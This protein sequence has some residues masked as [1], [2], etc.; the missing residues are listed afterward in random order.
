M[1]RGPS[2]R[3]CQLTERAEGHPHREDQ[4][5]RPT[6]RMTVINGEINDL[7][8]AL[9][10]GPASTTTA[11]ASA[12]DG[13]RL[14]QAATARRGTARRRARKTG[15]GTQVTYKG[16]PL[17]LFSNEGLDPTTLT[18]AGNGNG[19]GGFSLVSP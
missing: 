1:L 10:S 4:A 8:L 15:L 16:H 3:G 6:N 11:R 2:P 7:R 18:A 17:Y 19:I 13:G 14:R 9:R 5:A 12:A